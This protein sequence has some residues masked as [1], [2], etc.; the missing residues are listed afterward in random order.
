MTLT[1]QTAPDFTLPRDGG[2]SVTLSALRGQPVVLY[3]Y[4]KDDTPGCTLEAQDFT[5]HL[6]AFAKAGCLVLGVSKD[7]VAAHDKFRA[8]YD[9]HVALLSDAGADV[10]ERYQ[11]WAEK[12]KYGKT[13]LGIVRATF[14]IDASGTVVR[15]WREVTVPGHVS[16]VLDAVKAL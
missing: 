9:L 12:S 7:T 5:L 8:K 1:G 10:C 2:D 6:D 14:L 13:Y 11:V 15:E 3:F 4:P 16:E